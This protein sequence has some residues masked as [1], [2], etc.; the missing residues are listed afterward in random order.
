MRSST[1]GKN[2]VNVAAII[3]GRECYKIGDKVAKLQ[4]RQQGMAQGEFQ[5]MP[6]GEMHISVATIRISK[7]DPTKFRI[8]SGLKKSGAGN[9]GWRGALQLR[10]ETSA[11]RQR[12]INILNEM[13]S[14][15]KTKELLQDDILQSTAGDDDLRRLEEQLQGLNV[16]ASVMD[17]VRTWAAAKEEAHEEALNK[18]RDELMDLQDELRTVLEEKRYLEET[19]IRG[20]G[21]DSGRG[22][23]AQGRKVG[24]RPRLDPSHSDDDM[25]RSDDESSGGTRPRPR[26]GS[27]SSRTS[28]QSVSSL[29]EEEDDEVEDT[30]AQ[31]A[32]PPTPRATARA[33]AQ[34]GAEL[35][36]EPELSEAAEDEGPPRDS[37]D[38]IDFF[39]VNEQVA[40]SAAE[41]AAYAA[42]AAERQARLDAAAR[43]LVA[44]P[45]LQIPVPARER[46]LPALWPLVKDAVGSDL[47]AVSL[48]AVFNEPLSLLQRAAEDMTYPLRTILR[49]WRF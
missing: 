10:A 44:G 12:W 49:V 48:P 15:Y 36:P 25:E 47:S 40:V 2:K 19:I 22:S 46:K 18:E 20:M 30:A 3:G 33:V 13:K 27:H 43:S 24:G 41:A 45:R 9:F 5:D 4:R 29:S 8:F 17:V 35:E 42:K 16:S 39:D 23:R 1:K 32:R 37:V 26:R 38:S 34:F 6:L 28:A 14:H 21:A 31:R 11:D 7:S